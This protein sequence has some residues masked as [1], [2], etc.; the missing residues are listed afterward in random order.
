MRLVGVCAGRVRACVVWCDM[1]PSRCVVYVC[2]CVRVDLCAC[3]LSAHQACISKCVCVSF[4]S[5]QCAVL[6]C[7]VPSSVLGVA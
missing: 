7:C 4:S 6:V 2:L 3:V 5:F 1:H